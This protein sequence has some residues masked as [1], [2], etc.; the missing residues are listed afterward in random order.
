[1]EGS[2]IRGPEVQVRGLEDIEGSDN[3]G[4]MAEAK[5]KRSDTRASWQ[6]AENSDIKGVGVEGAGVERPGLEGA[7]VEGTGVELRGQE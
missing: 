6:V 1:M 3:R 2:V 4:V 5:A 7:R